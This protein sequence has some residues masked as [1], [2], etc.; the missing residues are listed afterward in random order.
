[1]FHSL[2]SNPCCRAGREV[3]IQIPPFS[4]KTQPTLEGLHS[5][6]VGRAES[7]DRQLSCFFPSS[8]ALSIQREML[9]VYTERCE[10]LF[11][12]SILGHYALSEESACRLTGRSM[13]CVCP[14]APHVWQPSVAHVY[15]R[16]CTCCNPSHF[17]RKQPDQLCNVF[18]RWGPFQKA[19]GIV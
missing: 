17:C 3:W 11:L 19:S 6:V 10:S 12:H 8:C 2:H 15:S 5:G 9:S 16:C 4:A 14:G 18:V 7:Y 13:V 1:M